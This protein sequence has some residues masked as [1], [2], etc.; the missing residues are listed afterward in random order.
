MIGIGIGLNRQLFAG[1]FANAYNTRVL[2]DGGTIE[3]TP[4]VNAASTLLQSASLLLIPS[5][6]KSGVAYSQLPNN[7][8]GDLTWTRASTANRTNSSG[9]IESVASGV[10][11]LSYMYSSCP[12]L[13]L[14]PQRTNLALRSEE[15]DNATWGKTRSII[16]SNVALAPN[17]I[18]SADLLESDST[19]TNG[20]WVRQT[21]TAF[22]GA[23]V[24]SVYAKQGTSPF[25]QIRV[26][27]IGGVIFNLSDGSIKQQ[28]SATG[29]IQSIGNGWYRCSILITASAS[30]NILFLVGN[31]SM[32]TTTW[33]TT[34]GYNLYIWGAQL[35]AG[36]F[37]TT[38]IPTTSATATRVADSFSRNNIY[39]NGL[40]TSSG[41]T[42]YVELKNNVSYTRDNVNGFFIGDN[43]LANNGN[44]FNIR[45]G[46]PG[47]L[48]VYKYIAGV[49]TLLYTTTTDSV[50]IAIKW[51][52]T[53]ADVFVNGVKQV[54][55][56]V[57]TTTLM[58]YLN[59]TVNA[60]TFIQSMALFSS[61]L[62][63]SDCATLTT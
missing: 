6:Y 1:G 33:A 55:A 57:Y 38:Y 18:N 50:K 53:T 4:C 56:T 17:N 54:S 51:N 25:I 11:R 3:A 61:P 42:W 10:P 30:T 19:Q 15:F 2:A 16:Y 24:L 21:L 36:S 48:I 62:S 60:P 43:T 29:Q 46:N 34:Q 63:D 14:E 41:G 31:S 58:E 12:A 35:E 44:Q 23:Y 26:D 39:T 32:T 5:G 22:T 47:R 52:G 49:A 37:A 9:L 59:A 8:N 28:T 40:I 7:G 45:Y 27:G 20:S 13:L